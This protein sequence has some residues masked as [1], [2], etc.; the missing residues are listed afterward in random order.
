M[1]SY[2]EYY[3]NLSPFDEE[4]ESLKN[5][6]REGV[7][8]EIKERLELLE[9]QNKEL[10]RKLKNL[11]TLEREAADTKREYERK[12]TMAE[13]TAMRTVQKEGLRKLLELLK[14]PR[15]RVNRNWEMGPK[16]GKCDE[17]RK[18]RYTTPLG[19]EMFEA[20]E[21]STRS[22]LWEVE[23]T[24]VHEVSR[25]DGKIIAWYHGTSRYFDDDS[26]GSPTVLHSCEGHTLEEMAKNPRDYGFPTAESAAVLATVLNKADQ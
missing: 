13:Q 19:R 8:K 16:C 17:E 6:L 12:L 25:R 21:C 23:E 10:T 22:A 9:T 14:E 5:H 2:D 15:Y 11:G 7:A 1:S 18:L 4:V 24:L 20:C 3:E 26:M